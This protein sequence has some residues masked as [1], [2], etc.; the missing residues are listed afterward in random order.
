MSYFKGLDSFPD[1]Y[2][3]SYSYNYS[4]NTLNLT[5][6]DFDS[7]KN[8][9]TSN[10]SNYSLGIDTLQKNFTLS[11]FYYYFNAKGSNEFDDDGFVFSIS[12]KISF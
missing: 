1:Y 8:D 5:Y 2:E 3:L 6:G 12:R 11:F 10:G 9:Q 7:Y 4:N